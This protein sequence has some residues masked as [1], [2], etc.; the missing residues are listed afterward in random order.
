MLCDYYIMFG[1]HYIFNIS[2]H[3]KV[4]NVLSIQEMVLCMPY[5]TKRS[6]LKLCAAIE[7]AF[8]NKL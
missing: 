1:Y 8:D 5:K 3:S 4:Q 7:A 6:L 2:C